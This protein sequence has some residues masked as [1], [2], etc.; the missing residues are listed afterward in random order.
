MDNTKSTCQ[1]CSLFIT[2]LASFGIAAK[3]TIS[4][5]VVESFRIAGAGAVLGDRVHAH[6]TCSVSSILALFNRASVREIHRAAY[7]TNPSSFISL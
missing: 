4:K 6:E 7:C 3:A 2:I 5:W 1:S